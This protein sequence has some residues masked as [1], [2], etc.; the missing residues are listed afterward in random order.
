ML[1]ITNHQGN[2]NQ[3]GNEI[4]HHTCQNGYHKKDEITS[5]GKEVEKRE[6]LC[7]VGINV[8]FVATMENSMKL[9]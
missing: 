6:H 3:N 1:T 4:L 2:A 8:N 7:T 5:V 9:P